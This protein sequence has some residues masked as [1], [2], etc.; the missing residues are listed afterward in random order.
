M[1]GAVGRETF[2]ARSRARMVSRCSPARTGSP[3]T[4]PKPI[5]TRAEVRPTTLNHELPVHEKQRMSRLAQAI[6]DSQ[7]L[8]RNDSERCDGEPDCRGCSV[9]PDHV[10]QDNR[11]MLAPQTNSD[12]VCP[13]GAGRPAPSR[14]YQT[15]L[16]KP[17]LNSWAASRRTGRP[18]IASTSTD[19]KLRW[20]RRNAMSARSVRHTHCGANTFETTVSRIGLRTSFSRS[21]STNAIAVATRSPPIT[22]TA[23]HPPAAP[24]GPFVE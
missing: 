17:A 24:R 20:R 10:W 12:L 3:P 8:P 22:T 1:T 23:T 9:E 11:P 18:S 14:P 2:L 5:Q 19:I 6:A 4:F 15:K 13:S 7:P 16:A 21:V